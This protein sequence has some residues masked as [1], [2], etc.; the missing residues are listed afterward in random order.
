MTATVPDCQTLGEMSTAKPKKKANAIAVARN[1]WKPLLVMRASLYGLA[2][3]KHSGRAR[4]PD[5]DLDQSGGRVGRGCRRSSA[6]GHSRR[7]RASSKSGDVRYAA[8]SGRKFRAL[9]GPRPAIAG[10]WRCP[11]RDSSSET[12][13]SNHAQRIQ[14]LRMD[15]LRCCRTNRVGFGV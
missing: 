11:R 15:R 10:W 1:S 14:R 9:T 12:G 4:G 6:V 13:A 2:L 8:G 7:G 5:L 3:Q